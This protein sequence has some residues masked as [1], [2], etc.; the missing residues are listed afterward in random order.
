MNNNNLSISR[1]VIALCLTAI[2]FFSCKKDGSLD[3]VPRDRLSDATVWTDPNTADVFLNDIYGKL[4]DGNNW[5]DPMENYSDNSVCGYNWPVSRNVI[6][7][8]SYNPATVIFQ[9]AYGYLPYDWKNQYSFIRKCNLFIES[10]T[11]SPELTDS[12]KKLR[13]AEVRFLR[14]YF[15]HILWMTYGGVPIVKNVLNSTEDGEAIF[16]PRSTSDETLNFITTECAAIAPDLPKV[17]AQGGRVSQGAALTLKGWC[18]LFAGKFADAAATNKQIID[19]LGGSTYT[20][21]PDYGAFFMPEN[22]TNKEG[23]FYRQYLP[24]VWGGRADSYY[25][26]TFT[27][28]GAETSW[29]AIGPTQEM[30][31]AYF[32]ANGKPITDPTSGYDPQNPYANREKRFYQSI[33]YD[34]TWWYNDT[35][36]TR[37]GMGSKNQ[38]DLA[39]RD[40]ATNTG[41]Y[42]RK[43]LNDKITLGADNWNN[44]GSSAQNYYYF[45][46][47]EVLLNYA[48]AQNE[49]A[50]P[51]ASV[52]TAI[53]A[54]RNR[55]ALP[56]LTTGLSQS[57]MRDAIRQER[58]VELAFED[59]RYWDLIRWKTA[60]IVLN[61]PLHGIAITGTQGN[62]VYTPVNIAGGT[63]KFINPTNYLFPIP[64]Y[65]IDQNP[66]L[67]GHQNPG[68]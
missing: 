17:P 51:D 66:K 12:Y 9:V 4:P 38:I 65:A 21:F 43:R 61:T 34:A 48:E 13:L 18:E 30:I 20:L 3:V 50:G 26:P 10:V 46:Y 64:Q 56:N 59:K 23:I 42:I 52:Y 31:D 44:P 62:F 22:N 60:H 16:I 25:G 5:Y 63:K 35:I 15:Y 57:A 58:R 55:S 19:Q 36:Y 49:A 28:G 54:I 40:D 45:R 67:Q 32:M 8:A 41:Y 1:P 39:D 53:N 2:G 37:Q 68:Y 33:V 14:A 29:G 24:R 6:Q 11:A 27:K 47:S 7:Q